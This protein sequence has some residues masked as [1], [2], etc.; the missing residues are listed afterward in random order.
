MNRKKILVKCF[1]CEYCKGYRPWGN[2]RTAF[3]CAHPNETY[4]K[5]YFREKNILKM[6]GFLG[7]GKAN[8]NIVP[9]KTSPAWCPL[10]KKTEN[11]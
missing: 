2:I 9:L 7:F 11:I 1:E 4:I 10:K 6:P 3:N 5:D 8:S